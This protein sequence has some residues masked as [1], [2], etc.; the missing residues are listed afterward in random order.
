MFQTGYIVSTCYSHQGLSSAFTGMSRTWQCLYQDFK[1]IAVPL[2]GLSSAST[3]DFAAPSQGLISA[4][5]RTQ[6][7]KLQGNMSFTMLLISYKQTNRL[8]AITCYYIKGSAVPLQGAT[9]TLALPSPRSSAGVA[10]TLAVPS[11]RS[12]A[13]VTRTSAVPSPRS[14]AGVTRHRCQRN[15][16]TKATPLATS[17]DPDRGHSSGVA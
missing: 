10:R 3:R 8:H 6:Q 15:H 4:F 12:S 7:C 16:A 1:V 5:A 14:S 9:R 17:P 11:P 2:Q 13:G